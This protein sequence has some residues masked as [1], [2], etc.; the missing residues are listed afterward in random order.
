MILLNQ[1]PPEKPTAREDGAL[2]VV[3]VFHTIQG[4][5]P[6]AGTPAVFVRLAG[7]N[8]QCPDC[9]TDYTSTRKF[10]SEEALA[11]EVAHRAGTVNLDHS[12]GT[13]L[14]VVTGGEPF[15]Q[16]LGPFVRRLLMA[17][18]LVQVETNGSLYQADF[19]YS[20]G[21][22]IVCSPKTGR[23]HEQL[24][25]YVRHLKYVVE[26][27]RLGKDGFPLQVL[28]APNLIA[29][30]WSGFRPKGTVWLQPADQQDPGLNKANL[31]ECV[32]ACLRHGF[33]LCL[34]V[35]KIVGLP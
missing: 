15:R 11:K 7:C 3:E 17:G 2:E 34:Q 29:R 12:P 35:H 27:G 31:K 16:N 33:R 4:E 22:T 14:V 32:D 28:G 21:V 26:A 8:L 23:V 1:Q 13:G 6:Y 25:P 9:D 10:V 18:W 19:P 5:G 30:P 20:G 24:Q